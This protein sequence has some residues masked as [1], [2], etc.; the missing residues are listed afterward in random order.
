MKNTDEALKLFKKAA[1]LGNK[2]AMFNLGWNISNG[3]L[4][5]ENGKKDALMYMK[6]ESENGDELTDEVLGDWFFTG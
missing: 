4:K 5:P 1:K 6:M 2:L 3:N